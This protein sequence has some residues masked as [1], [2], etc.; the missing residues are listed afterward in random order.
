MRRRVSLVAGALAVL[1]HRPGPAGAQAPMPAEPLPA[2]QRIP[3]GSRPVPADSGERHLAN[4]RQLTFGG[5]NAEAYFSANGNYLTFQGRVDQTGCDQQFVVRVADGGGLT[6]VSPGEGKTTCGFFYGD[7]R[8]VLFGSTH[9]NARGCPAPPDR[10]RGYVWKLDAYDIYTAARD[11]ADVRRLT[12]YGTYTAEAVVSPDGRRVVFTS[13]KDGDLDIYTMNVDGTDVRQLT[14]TLGYDGGPWWSPDGTRIVYRAWHPTDSADVAQYR[15]L[16]A[17]RLVKPNRMELW[18]MNADGSGQRQ[19][20]HLGGANFGPSW[21]ADGRRLIFSSNYRQP[22][23]G[24]FDLYLVNLDGTGLEQVT[25]SPTFDGFP[26]FSRDGRRLVWASNR[27]G[28]TAG[29]TNL[30]VADWRE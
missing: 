28:A 8:R 21:T 14:H 17:D 12:N 7:D 15:A 23:T 9:D 22:R 24:N 20:T 18:V 30:F 10:S 13:L 5:E 29:E 16:L 27:R 19:I 2:A 6:R 1:A 3:T 25:T 26:M 11:G 4:V